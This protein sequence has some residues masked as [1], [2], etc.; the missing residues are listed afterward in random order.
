MPGYASWKQL[1]QEEYFQMK[2][3]G[4]DLRGVAAP[5][6]MLFQLPVPAGLQDGAAPAENEPYWEKAYHALFARYAQ[7]PSVD[8][9]FDE[10]V[11]LAAIMEKAPAMP[12][13]GA[14]VRGEAYRQRIQGAFSGR[15]A[16]VALGKPLEMGMD[17]A[18]IERYLRSVDGYPLNDFVPARSPKLNI[19][20]REDCLPSTR[21]NVQY[22]Q[23]DD[24][25]HYT[26]LALALA[27]SKGTSFTAEDVGMNWLD[28][29][30]YHWF[31]CASRQAYYHMVNLTEDEDRAAQIARIPLSLNPWRECIDGQIR[32]DLWGY[33]RPGEPR[34]AAEIAYRDCAFSLVKNGCYG[35]MFVAGCI[36][37]A[38]TQQPSVEAIIRS[39][40]ACI[41]QKSRLSDAVRHVMDWYQADGDWIRT[42]TRIEQAYGH[43]PFAA[44]INNLCMVTLALLE[45]NLDYT[46][47]IT[48][49][50]MCGIDTDCNAG[51]AGSIVGAA[52]GIDAIERRWIDPLH[53]TIRSAVASFGTC[54]ISQIEA[55]ICALGEA[56]AVHAQPLPGGKT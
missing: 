2:E 39:G 9:P 11:A 50:V 4:F 34:A 22:M 55:R 19:T 37:A 41:P 40:L 21:G 14:P 30:P 7:G 6:D 3:E 20:L 23:A 16:A 33:I 18:A 47:T 1:Y 32:C 10:P 44:T 5:E 53:D 49:A 17:R 56:H 54:S 46:R 12:G 36:A 25:I 13:L 43:L 35:G 31:W 51:T 28:N 24:D 29:V 8:F 42:C 26:L 15:C 52:V 38:L 27:E 48:T 45:G